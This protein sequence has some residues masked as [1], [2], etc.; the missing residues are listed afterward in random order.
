MNVEPIEQCSKAQFSVHNKKKHT[1]GESI[2]DEEDSW[3]RAAICS[4]IYNA[5]TLSVL[6]LC[7]CN[8]SACW[9]ITSS[10]N[11]VVVVNVSFRSTRIS[12]YSIFVCSCKG[13]KQCMSFE[14]KEAYLTKS[15]SY[16]HNWSLLMVLS[17][18]NQSSGVI[19]ISLPVLHPEK[20]T[21]LSNFLKINKERI[22]IFFL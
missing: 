8:R 13:L 1:K 6:Q 19:S 20:A 3:H 21:K 5:L 22:Q 14:E 17:T 16:V 18:T 11:W 12:N 2:R 9:V 15:S 10:Y 7:Q 4:Y